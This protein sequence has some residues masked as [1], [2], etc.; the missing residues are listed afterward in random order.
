MDAPGA[1]AD[2]DGQIKS[3]GGGGNIGDA[4]AFGSRIQRTPGGLRSAWFTNKT[5]NF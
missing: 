4:V 2:D 1:E 3:P 5:G